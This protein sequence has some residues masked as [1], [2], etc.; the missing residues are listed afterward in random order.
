MGGF[1]SY[2]RSIYERAIGTTRT[3]RKTLGEEINYG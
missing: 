3:L 2:P 1:S